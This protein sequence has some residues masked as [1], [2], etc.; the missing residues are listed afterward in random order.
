MKKGFFC[1]SLIPLL[2]ALSVSAYAKV[3]V[4]SA[5]IHVPPPNTLVTAGY[6]ELINN[7]AQPVKLQSVRCQHPAITRCELHQ[8]IHHGAQHQMRKADLVLA[9]GA[10]VK[11]EPG[12][13]HLMLWLNSSLQ[14]GDQ[15]DV[16]LDFD[17]GQEL[18]F[19][20][21]VHGTSS[22]ENH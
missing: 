12:A 15:V 9:P 21:P 1:L 8:T 10:A 22:H 17:S 18:A 7:A 20:L 16:N 5:M 2:G 4:T 6:F 19:T 11:L 13:W 3:N 14:A